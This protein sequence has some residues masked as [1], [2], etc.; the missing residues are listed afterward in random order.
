V[1]TVILVVLGIPAANLI[2]LLT[3]NK[4]CDRWQDCRDR[5]K[6]AARA[7]ATRP[8]T[9]A[10]PPAAPDV[11]TPTLPPPAPAAP[12]SVADFRPVGGPDKWW[13]TSPWGW[14]GRIVR[15]VADPDCPECRGYGYR[16]RLHLPRPGWPYWIPD[17]H[18]RPMRVPHG[19]F[20]P[21]CISPGLAEELDH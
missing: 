11:G 7:A 12:A 6:S 16:F 13:N 20:C 3:F 17:A 1:G 2:I 21:R 15:A 9:A 5:R 19:G 14:E 8:S 4:L 18:G 10:S